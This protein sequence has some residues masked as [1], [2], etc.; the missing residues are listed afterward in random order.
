MLRPVVVMA[1]LILSS[2]VLAHE[3]APSKPAMTVVGQG[4]VLLAPDTAFVTLGMETTGRSVG[5]AERQNRLV[6]SKVVERLKA[7]HIENERI[8]TASFTVSPQY[9]PPPKRSDAPA[10]PPEIIGYVVSNTVTVEVRNLEKVGPVIEE[11][12]AAGANQLQS[13]QWGIRDE[14]QAKVAALKQAASKAREKAAALSEALKVK[15]TRLLSATEESRIVRPVPR[16]ARSMVAMES[17]GGEAAVFS[18]EIRVEAT[19]SVVY[20]MVQD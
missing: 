3:E 2:E 5:D 20:E 6:M 9:K 14:Q 4:H 17:G 16:M 11:S 12:L 10:G 1:I 19:V 13:L 8:Q 15:L 18:G 7:L